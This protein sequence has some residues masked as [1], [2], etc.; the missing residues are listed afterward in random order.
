MITLRAFCCFCGLLIAGCGWNNV[1]QQEP[2][3]TVPF[4][5]VT[6]TDAVGTNRVVVLSNCEISLEEPY[7][8]RD[9]QPVVVDPGPDGGSPLRVAFVLQITNLGDVVRQIAWEGSVND[10]DDVLYPVQFTDKSQTPQY[11]VTLAP[12]EK[13]TIHLVNHGGP[14]LPIGSK[15]SLS[16]RFT[17]DDKNTGNITTLPVMINQTM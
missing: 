16:L 13:Y 17:V 11:S 12:G 15:A 3:E 7:F 8:W 10:G 5:K 6:G 4:P 9:W 1:S 14:Y 2:S